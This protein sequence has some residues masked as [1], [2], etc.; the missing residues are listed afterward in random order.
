MTSGVKEGLDAVE[1]CGV[2]G[3]AV[4]G[5]F[6]DTGDVSGYGP[7]WRRGVRVSDVL[8]KGCLLGARKW[9][10]KESTGKVR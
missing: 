9:V 7:P 4:V 6:E 3:W 10:L 5:V 2:G 8:E 1:Y